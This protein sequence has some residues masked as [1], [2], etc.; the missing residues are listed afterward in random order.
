VTTGHP[1]RAEARGVY[2]WLA[3]RFAEAAGLL[4]LAVAAASS[5]GAPG[6]S[7][8]E[9]LV[10][11]AYATPEEPGPARAAP[12]E[13]GAVAFGVA[14]SGDDEHAA[15]L[16]EETHA[17]LEELEDHWAAGVRTHLA[18]GE[19]EGLQTAE[20]IA[21]QPFQIAGLLLDAWVA[22]HREEHDE[23]VADYRAALAIARH[24]SAPH[25][26]SLAAAKSAR[27]LWSSP[28]A[29]DELEGA[30]H[31]LGSSATAAALYGRV[32]DWSKAWRP[33]QPRETFLDAPAGSPA[34]AALEATA[35]PST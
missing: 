21:H 18:D 22:E 23:A 30:R 19:F 10:V 4:E 14:V 31:S 17:R 20:A 13:H 8:I 2:F 34:A 1:I 27:E 12:R 28:H 11:L 6:P 35:E 33:Q 9:M 29:R 32:V 15:I 25:E 24:D 5:N 16:A 26:L 3:D 7:R